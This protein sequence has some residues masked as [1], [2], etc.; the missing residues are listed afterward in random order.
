MDDDVHAAMTCILCTSYGR[1]ESIYFM[2]IICLLAF[3]F[4]VKKFL[5]L[6]YVRTWLVRRLAYY[7]P[8]SSLYIRIVQYVQYYT[9]VGLLYYYQDSHLLWIAPTAPQGRVNFNKKIRPPYPALTNLLWRFALQWG[10]FLF[11]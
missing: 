10:E 9:L 7:C 11:V 2:F 8:Y 3:R 6:S 1:V 5:D 4:F